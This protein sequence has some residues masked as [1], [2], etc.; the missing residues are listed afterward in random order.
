MTDALPI[1][2]IL[3]PTAGGKTELAVGL[4]QRL[5]G[6]GECICADSMQVYRGMDIGTAKPTPRQRAEVE[7]HLLNLLE[8]HQDG[9]SVDTW[10]DLAERAIAEIR[11]R[12]RY[13][14]VVGGTNL[15]V[16]ALLEG[17]FDGPEPDPELRRRLEAVDPAE[18]RRQLETIDP[19]A[20]SQIHPNDRRRT[21]R[22]IEVYRLTGRRISDLQG[23]WLTGT[24]RRDVRIIGLDYPVQTINNRINA[25]ART[26]IRDGL[27]DE[28]KR[29]MAAG[30]LGRQASEALGYRQVLEHLAGRQ[31]LDRTLEQI[32]V[33]TR[34]YAKQQR[35]WL[36]RF[37]VHPDS[38]WIAAEG[39]SP[40]ELVEKALEAVLGAEKPAPTGLRPRAA[41]AAFRK[42]FLDEAD[43]ND[44]IL[45]PTV[46]RDSPGHTHG[47]ETTITEEDVDRTPNRPQ[48]R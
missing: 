17:I 19:T 46:G 8:P 13:P 20:A 30:G 16:Q 1:I 41:S 35:S 22:A 10:L 32:R 36:R 47:Q 42:D 45:P 9:F 14:I 6:G 40:Q 37:R 4:A 33:R 28:V 34:R 43:L 23:Q 26:M 3:G 7:H 44:Q 48:Q 25:R 2:L 15:Y 21:V 27:V 39:L 29:L 24:P 12:G 5:P 31:S 38:S 11:G 18:L